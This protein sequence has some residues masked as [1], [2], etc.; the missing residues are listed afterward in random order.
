MYL[1]DWRI[2]ATRQLTGP[3]TRGPPVVI[4]LLMASHW[5]ARAARPAIRPSRSG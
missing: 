2:D 1:T 4:R 3:G 5:A